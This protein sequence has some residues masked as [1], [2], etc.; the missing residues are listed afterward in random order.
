[1]EDGMF[2]VLKWAF[3]SP[4]PE[5]EILSK[6]FPG[7]EITVPHKFEAICYRL[8]V[9]YIHLVSSEKS[10]I[11]VAEHLISLIALLNEHGSFEQYQDYASDLSPKALELALS[12]FPIKAPELAKI[13]A[14]FLARIIFFSAPFT[15]E[16][17]FGADNEPWR[18]MYYLLAMTLL[19]CTSREISQHPDKVPIFQKIFELTIAMQER[20]DEYVDAEAAT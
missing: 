19:D 16:E 6:H 11:E 5:L 7:Q 12:R 8:T 2:E 3:E 13:S 9:A 10:D 14:P 17:D 4:I 18:S 20:C 15:Q 1:M